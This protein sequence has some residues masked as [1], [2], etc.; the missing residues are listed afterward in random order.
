MTTITAKIDTNI[1]HMSLFGDQIGVEK[2]LNESETVDI[3]ERD[4]YART[5]L[6][7]AAKGG[8]DALCTALVAKEADPNAIDAN[9]LTPLL[10]AALCGHETT[11]KVLIAAGTIFFLRCFY[12]TLSFFLLQNLQNINATLFIIHFLSFSFKILTH[13]LLALFHLILRLRCC[14]YSNEWQFCN[15]SCLFQRYFGHGTK[16][17]S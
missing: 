16:F 8:K 2:Y 17:R 15:P 14:N 6:H 7:W 5:A 3:N 10:H 11:V 12:Y 13:H 1:H 9:G 4:L